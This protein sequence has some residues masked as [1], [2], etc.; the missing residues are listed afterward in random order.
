[1]ISD[2]HLLQT[3]RDVADA[4]FAAERIVGHSLAG[5]IPSFALAISSG[6]E[7]CRV[8][9]ERWRSLARAAL[10]AHRMGDARGAPMVR[11]LMLCRAVL[12]DAASA[13]EAD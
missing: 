11:F 7:H 3:A 4:R 1:M 8:L 9:A 10:V 2:A 5:I 12:L 13:W 6:P